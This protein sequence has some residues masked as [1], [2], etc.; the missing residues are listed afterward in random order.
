MADTAAFSPLVCDLFIK[1]KHIAWYRFVTKRLA[2]VFSCAMWCGLHSNLL[3]TLGAKAPR[4]TNRIECNPN[5]IAHSK[6][7]AKLYCHDSSA[8]SHDRKEEARS[9]TKSVSTIPGVYYEIG[10]IK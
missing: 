4:V 10:L 1:S 6:T 7:P 5:Q 3:V 2:E 8:T 9:L